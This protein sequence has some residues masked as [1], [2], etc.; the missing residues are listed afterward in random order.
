MLILIWGYYPS[1]NINV[2]IKVNS[3]INSSKGKSKSQPE[4]VSLT[5]MC[6]LLGKLFNFPDPQFPLL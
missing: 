3:N 6:K 5:R 4:L 1:I 2:N